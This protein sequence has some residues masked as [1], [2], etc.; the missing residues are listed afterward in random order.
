[1][2]YTT[3]YTPLNP[4]QGVEQFPVI[5][6]DIDNTLYSRAVDDSGLSLADEGRN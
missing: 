1:M 4:R 5:W 3:H 2:Q 6:F